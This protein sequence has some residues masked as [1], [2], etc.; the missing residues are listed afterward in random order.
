MAKIGLKWQ[1]KSKLTKIKGRMRTIGV[2]PL[3]PL[4][5]KSKGGDNSL[6]FSKRK[7]KK[8]EIFRPF[9]CLSPSR[10]QEPARQ[11]LDAASQTSEPVR[12]AS[13]P[14]R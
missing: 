2:K 8:R 10:V 13:E 9:V 4:G 6:A 5:E 3:G 1:K 12:Q 14:A 7:G 11:A